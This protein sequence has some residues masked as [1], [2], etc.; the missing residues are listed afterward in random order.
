MKSNF[1][2]RPE[3][4]RRGFR[5]AEGAGRSAEVREV[6]GDLFDIARRLREIDGGYFVLRRGG[7]FEVHNRRDVPTYCLTVP[8]S[9]LDARTV[10]LVRRTRAERAAEIFAEMER[11]NERLKRQAVRESADRAAETAERVLAG[12]AVLRAGGPPG[13]EI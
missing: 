9:E 10:E 3:T 13:E 7:K 2:A 4:A 12:E 5:A 6:E 8:W 11:H 1:C